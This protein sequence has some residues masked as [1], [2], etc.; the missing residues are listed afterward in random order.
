MAIIPRRIRRSKFSRKTNQANK[1]VSTPSKLRSKEV[2]E[3]GGVVK[4]IISKIGP[5]TP[6]EKMAPPSHTQSERFNAGSQLAG[7]RRY[8]RLHLQSVRP[9]PE[10]RYR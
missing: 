6:P 10:P 1:A 4:P 7:S 2:L 3:A 5:T 8:L 9:I